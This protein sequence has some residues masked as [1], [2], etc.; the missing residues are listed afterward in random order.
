MP[1][2]SDAF[3]DLDR[4]LQSTRRVLERF[5][6]AHAAWRP[7][8]KSRPIGELAW[9]IGGIPL[10]GA[11]I[12]TTDGVDMAGMRPT[13][14][15]TI[16]AAAILKRFDDETAR[17]RGALAAANPAALHGEWTMRAGDRV[18]VRDTRAMLMRYMVISHMIHHRAQLGVYYR[19]LGVP[20]PGVYGP[21]ADEAI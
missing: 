4:E 9:H 14:P 11:E 5:P 7:H 18:L 3:P 17:L 21:S 10:R 6:D 1:I 8:E 2:P 15:A 13:A 16:T 20:V 12:L 19:L